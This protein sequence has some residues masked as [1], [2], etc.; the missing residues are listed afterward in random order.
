M[1]LA[2]PAIV[3]ATHIH[4]EHGV[5]V[6]AL[7]E[8]DGVQSGY[9]RGGRSRGHRPVLQPANIII[10]EWRA[11]TESQL[12]SLAVELVQSRAALHEGPLSAAALAWLSALTVTALPEGHPYPRLYEALGA[13]F[14]LIEAASSA[15]QW[16]GGVARY[17]LLLLAELGFGLDLSRCVVSGES[18][19]LAFVSPKSGGAVSRIAATAYEDRLLPLP[20]F[21]RD[22][23]DAGWPDIFAA[24]AI[25]GRFIARDVLVDRRGITLAARD[26]LIDGLKR[27]VA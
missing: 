17:E 4:G 5:I 24:L 7:T 22:G 8:L 16:A 13:L 23:G 11:R 15:R 26:R 12:P 3:L 20:A 27:A 18:D 25:T 2:A 19:D 10:G 14:G 6:R 9:V 21:L 1:H